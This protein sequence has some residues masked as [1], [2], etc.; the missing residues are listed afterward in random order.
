M[1]PANTPDSDT[2]HSADDKA[3]NAL[4][5]KII[6]AVLMVLVAWGMAIFA[7]GV[8]ALY[9]PAVALVPVIYIALIAMARG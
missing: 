9:L 8:P 6:F 3:E 5:A 7:W 1:T 4:A 2:P